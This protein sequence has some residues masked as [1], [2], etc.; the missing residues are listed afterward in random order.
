MANETSVKVNKKQRSVGLDLLR[1]IA[2]MMVVILHY[3]GKGELLPDMMKAESWTAVGV[4]AWAL[5]AISIVAVNVY[6]LISGYLL[7][8]SHFKLSRLISLYI[9][10]WTYSAGVGLVAYMTGLAPREEMTTYKLLSLILPVSMGHYW[11]M[12]AYVYFYMLLPLLGLAVKKMT[13]KQHR[14]TVI[15][16]LLV[17][18]VLKSVLP[19]KLEM[20]GE[21][22]DFLWYSIMFMVAAYIRR[23][24][25]KFMSRKNSTVMMIVGMLG[26]FAEIM[27]L[28]KFGM[29]TGK[30]E[31]ISTVSMHYN[32]I[33]PFLGALGLFGL[34]IPRAEK[35]ASP[36]G[37]LIVFIAPFTLGVYLLHENTAVRYLWQEWFQCGQAD[38]VPKLIGYTILATVAIFVTG[39]IF[40]I[41]R[42]KLTGLVHKGMLHIKPYRLLAEKIVGVDKVFADKYADIK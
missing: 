36:V 1:C 8:E 32:H 3:L 10:L 12:T 23:Y 24:S 21:G 30:F 7:C 33:F 22:Y 6:M 16:L 40:E 38:N 35:I 2:M 29:M 4:V 28:G 39:V 42:S 15:I 41:I 17:I 37:K 18:C 13:E 26:S 34:F 25:P 9:Q 14:I 20:D 11:F 31:Y 5:E 27:A 19:V